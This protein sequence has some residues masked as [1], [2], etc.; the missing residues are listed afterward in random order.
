LFFNGS[1][2]E[3]NVV[4]AHSR[5]SIIDLSEKGKQP[6]IRGDYVITYNGEVYNYPELKTQ[7]EAKGELLN[8]F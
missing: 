8:G 3:P 1:P 4:F 6:M 7:L 5:L 2:G